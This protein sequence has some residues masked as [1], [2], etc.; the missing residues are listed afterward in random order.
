MTR[1][2]D[3]HFTDVIP[4]RCEGQANLSRNYHDVRNVQL[5]GLVKDVLINKEYMFSIFIFVDMKGFVVLLLVGA[6]CG[7]RFDFHDDYFS[8]AFVNY[9]NSRNDVSWKVWTSLVYIEILIFF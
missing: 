6:A 8:E 5:V 9:H 3:L 7:Y 1:F 2:I 4:L